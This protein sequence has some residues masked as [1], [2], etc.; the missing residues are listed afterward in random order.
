MD[1]VHE[2]LDRGASAGREDRPVGQGPEGEAVTWTD[3]ALI[4][5]SVAVTVVIGMAVIARWVRFW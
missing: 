3:V 5:G 2:V 1:Q 4:V